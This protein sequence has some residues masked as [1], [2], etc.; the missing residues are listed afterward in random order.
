MK[1]IQLLIDEPLLK[2]LDADPEVREV[3]RSEVLRRAATA[4]LRRSRARR[5]AELSTGFIYQVAVRGVTGERDALPADLCER[6]AALRAV[7]GK[8]ICAGFGV[9]TAD[10]VRQVRRVADGVIVGSAI[11][12]PAVL[13]RSSSDTARSATAA[14]LSGSASRTGCPASASSASPG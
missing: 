7:T 14:G 11:V 13:R 8:P 4:Y 12:R 6:V 10:Q 5:I 2:R 9:G 3:G 1:P